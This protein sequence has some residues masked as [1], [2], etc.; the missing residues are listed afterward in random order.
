MLASKFKIPAV[1][2][3]P[4]ACDVRLF[5]FVA[6]REVFSRAHPQGRDGFVKASDAEDLRS[7][8]N[9][10]AGLDKAGRKA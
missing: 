10:P 2:K 7:W 8:R 4:Q 3:R 6:G 9:Y 5:S 1:H